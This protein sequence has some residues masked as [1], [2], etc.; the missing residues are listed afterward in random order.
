MSPSI[1][2]A[3]MAATASASTTGTTSNH[4]PAVPAPATNPYTGR[5]RPGASAT[6]TI[7]EPSIASAVPRDSDST[8]RQ[9]ISVASP[10]AGPATSAR[11]DSAAATQSQKP[12]TNRQP[13]P[14]M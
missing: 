4:D 10:A 14:L 8:A 1:R 13:S 9:A 5:G 12:M 7:A 6:T 11:R 3:E 2:G